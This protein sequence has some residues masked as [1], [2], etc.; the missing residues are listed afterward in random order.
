MRFARIF[1]LF[2]VTT[3]FTVSTSV[4]AAE[5]L[6]IGEVGAIMKQIALENN[7]LARIQIPRTSPNPQNQ[8][9]PFV[10]EINSTGFLYRNNAG[11]LRIVTVNH[12]LGPTPTA[13]TIWVTFGNG[14]GKAEIVGR[15]PAADLALLKVPA[16]L[17]EGIEPARF[18]FSDALRVG[19]VVFAAGFPHELKATTF[20]VVIALEQIPL[21]VQFPSWLYVTTQTPLNPGNS[22]GP[23]LNRNREVVGINVS[24]VPLTAAVLNTPNGIAVVGGDGGGMSFS[25]NARIIGRLLA[26]LERDKLVE[27][28]SFD[29]SIRETREVSPIMY[30][31][32]TEKDYPPPEEGVMVYEVF[33][34][35]ASER[36]GLRMGDLLKEVRFAERRHVVTTRRALEEFI[37]FEVSP[38]TRGEVVVKRNDELVTIPISFM[39]LPPLRR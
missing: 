24:I 4:H 38:N 29:F 20:G 6:D 35:T 9:E 2:I 32:Y 11:E 10:N 23:L 26:R 33:T 22:G 31:Y 12:A 36:A 3:F 30:E 1:A 8:N 18:N 19:D 21:P 14:F 34:D 17:T 27:H 25:L 37:F 13:T 39:R 16:W 7:Y 15:D 28:A 5:N